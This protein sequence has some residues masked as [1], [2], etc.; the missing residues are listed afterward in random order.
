MWRHTRRK[1]RGNWLMEWVA[2]TLHTTSVC[3]IS[4][5]ATADAHT[6]AA[7]SRMNW[8]PRRFKWTRPFR[9][10]KNYGL[11]SCVITFQLTSTRLTVWGLASEKFKDLCVMYI[12]RVALYART[13]CLFWCGSEMNVLEVTLNE[14]HF[15][16]PRG[17]LNMGVA[18][19]PKL[20]NFSTRLHGA[21]CC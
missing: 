5:I 1:W 6:S 14:A 16:H 19:S 7:S 12:Y 9:R 18:G 10:R 8:H 21:T 15:V 4:S 17:T 2:S 20:R 11:C 3:V 13:A